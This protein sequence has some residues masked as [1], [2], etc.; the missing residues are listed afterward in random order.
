MGALHHAHNSVALAHEC[1]YK[2]LARAHN[3]PYVDWSL[4]QFSANAHPRRKT[5]NTA[6]AHMDTT[7]AITR[8]A[9]D[10]TRSPRALLENNAA[11]NF[12]RAD[13]DSGPDACYVAGAIPQHAR[14][15]LRF[16]TDAHVPKGRTGAPTRCDM[17]R[18]AVPCLSTCWQHVTRRGRHLAM[19]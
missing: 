7:T 17:R 11:R 8:A 6:P 9:R 2:C 13:S 14:E 1:G 15:P 10:E 18:S 12:G 4:W 16:S 5:G 3:T 19:T